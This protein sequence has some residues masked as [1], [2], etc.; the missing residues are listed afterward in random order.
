MSEI[1]AISQVHSTKILLLWDLINSIFFHFINS[2][3]QRHWLANPTILSI[4][5]KM[6]WFLFTKHIVFKGYTRCFF[7]WGILRRSHAMWIQTAYD[8]RTGK[9]IYV[10]WIGFWIINQ[11]IAL[12]I[13]RLSLHH[14]L[15]M[16]APSKLI[17]IYIYI[18]VYN[19]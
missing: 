15:Y 8:I 2:W 17:Y 9:R 3:L 18:Y 6:M 1:W 4:L 14:Y 19:R 5:L 13:K 10:F 7:I 11:D 12:C 16:S